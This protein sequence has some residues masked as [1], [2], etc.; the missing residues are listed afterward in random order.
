M[1]LTLIEKSLPTFKI[2][3]D[4]FRECYDIISWLGGYTGFE[5]FNGKASDSEYETHIRKN[6]MR[7][8]PYDRQKETNT[9]ELKR[10]EDMFI[11]IKL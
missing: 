2:K 1:E 11:T 10:L 4:S 6:D 3:A 7:M 5:Q 8:Y 9:I